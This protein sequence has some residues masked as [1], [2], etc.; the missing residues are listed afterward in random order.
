MSWM[1]DIDGLKD[2]LLADRVLL[3]SALLSCSSILRSLAPPN[4][5]HWMNKE[6]LGYDQCD[7][8]ILKASEFGVARTIRGHLLK[9]EGGQFVADREADFIIPCGVQTIELE[10]NNLFDI[11]ILESG[12]PDTLSL[13]NKV[14]LE[15]TRCVFEGSNE[16]SYLSCSAAAL[17]CCYYDIKMLFSAVLHC[18]PRRL[19]DR[20]LL[21]K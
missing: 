17:L 16:S 12:A 13:I 3:S 15:H 4:L 11:A 18:L 8:E 7:G 9:L 20:G 14:G 2:N 10:L 5:M 19:N 1:T 21:H 6:L